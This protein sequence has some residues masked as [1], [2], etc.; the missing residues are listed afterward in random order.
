VAYYM[1]DPKTSDTRQ[2]MSALP[3]ESAR[4]GKL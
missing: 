4:L 2:L 3:L 1:P